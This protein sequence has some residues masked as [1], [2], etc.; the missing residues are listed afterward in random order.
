MKGTLTMT[1]SKLKI[2]IWFILLFLVLSSNF[3]LYKTQLGAL[4]L[5][6]ETNP[7]VIGSLID[8]IIIAPI[9]FMLYKKKFSWKMAIALIAT[10]CIAAKLIIPASYLQ[11]FD[12]ITWTGIALEA[13]IVIFE[14]SL[15]ISFVRYLPKIR[16]AVRSSLLPAVFSFPQAVDQYV[17]KN[18]IIH[19]ICSEAL[20]F[21]YA[22]F[23]WKKK[24]REGITIY[25]NSS[26]IAF[27]I[28][29]IHAVVIETLGV[30]WLLHMA[31]I[32]PIVSIIMLILN[33]YG[34]IFFLGDIQALRLNPLYF[35]EKSIYLSQGLMKRV[36]VHFDNIDEVITDKEVLQSKLPKDILDFVAKDFE[37]VYPDV[38]IKLRTPIKA[39]LAMGLQKEYTQVAIRTDSP[40]EFLEKLQS[41]IEN[42]KMN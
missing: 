35:N 16:N 7:V 34:I 11:P 19:V 27:Q 4:V 42:N 26:L 14:L 22:F 9:L 10:G 40:N 6:E 32:S 29:L 13:A 33:I 21:Y 31:G 28:M 8:F 23:S 30:H 2:N 25:K 41:G 38:I 20:M 1:I 17:T 12:T 18:P 36:E 37:K 15:I 3:I 5:T 39:T 24:P